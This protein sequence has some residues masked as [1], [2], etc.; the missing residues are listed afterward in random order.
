MCATDRVAPFTPLR[1][2]AQPFC[3]RKLETGENEMLVRKYFGFWLCA[4]GMGLL[5]TQAVVVA[6]M[7]NTLTTGLALGATGAYLGGIR[8]LSGSLWRVSPLGSY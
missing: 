1:G 6:M 4:I 8:G 3:S 2:A 5:R 7:M